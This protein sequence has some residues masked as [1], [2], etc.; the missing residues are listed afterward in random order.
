MKAVI[1]RVTEA[2]VTV[3]G[4]VT[5]EIGPGFLVLLGVADGD[6]EREAAL[7]AGKAARLR[8]FA[9]EAGKMNLS[10]LDTGNAALVISQFTLCAD[11]KK[12]NRPAFTPAAP[13][14]L[15]K[16]LYEYFCEC[17]IKEG[18]AQVQTGVFGASMHVE[19]ANHGP[20]TIIMDTD[21]WR[22]SKC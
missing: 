7:L 18:V 22:N 16:A 15:A 5:G 21:I 6:T 12:G 13:P 3:E 1:Q 20:V 11:M 19:L 4:A 14:E 17:L 10:L 2:R 9:D 8:V